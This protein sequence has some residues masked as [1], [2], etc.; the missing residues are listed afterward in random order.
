MTNFVSGI[1]ATEESKNVPAT[2]SQLTCNR[3]RSCGTK[4]LGEY[5]W[6][7]E[8]VNHKRTFHSLETVR[9]NVDGDS[10]GFLIVDDSL[11][12]K[13]KSTKKSKVLITI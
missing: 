1:V 3:N 8:Y 11:S 2:Y 5:K 10:I 4:F 9:K 12:Q 13:D 6:S 7:N